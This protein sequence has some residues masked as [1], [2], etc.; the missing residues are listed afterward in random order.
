MPLQA[1]AVSIHLEPV[2]NGTRP[3]ALSA[4]RAALVFQLQNKKIH[5]PLRRCIRVLSVFGLHQT[6]RSVSVGHRSRRHGGTV[7]RSSKDSDSP[8]LPKNGN[9]VDTDL[10][11]RR[12]VRFQP[13]L[14]I[15]RSLDELDVTSDDIEAIKLTM[16]SLDPDAPPAK[17]SNQRNYAY[18]RNVSQSIYCPCSPPRAE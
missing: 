16:D 17:T 7:T 4:R 8:E 3:T 15:E 2:L 11:P 18:E 1:F 5:T 12:P 9:G 6:F 14:S 13:K 10:P